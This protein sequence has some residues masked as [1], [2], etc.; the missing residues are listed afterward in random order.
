MMQLKLQLIKHYSEVIHTTP[1][2]YQWPIVA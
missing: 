1:M 2:Q